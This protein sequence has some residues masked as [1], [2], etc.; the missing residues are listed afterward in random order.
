MQIK[1]VSFSESKL[2]LANVTHEKITA[3]IKEITG[4]EES[5]L[6]CITQK[7]MFAGIKEGIESAEI[8]LVAVDISRFISTKASLFRA[9]GFKCRLNSE[10]VQLIGSDACMATLN[11]NQINAHAAIPVGGEAFVTND[12]LFSGFGIKSGKQK[13]IFVPIDD[14]RI[15]AV[16]ENGMVDFI[17]G[18]VHYKV[19]QEEKTEEV[20]EEEITEEIQK[21]EIV[22]EN[23]EDVVEETPEETPEEEAAETPAVSDIPVEMEGYVQ[24]I[25]NFQ[26]PVAPV[27]EVQEQVSEEETEDETEESD[28]EFEDIASSSYD[29]NNEEEEVS[30][31]S[32]KV[33]V[34]T[35]SPLVSN[36]AIILSRGA[37]IAVARQ[38]ENE[39]YTDVL[40]EIENSAAVEFVDFPL[41]KSIT[42]DIRRKESVASN[43]RKAMKQ[44]NADFAISI[45]E[46]YK[47]EDGAE[48]I[49][50]TL[51][52]E[53]KSSVFKIFSVTGETHRDLYKTGLE[54]IVEKIEEMSREGN[55]QH[56]FDNAQQDSQQSSDKKPMGLATKLII[57]VLAVVA[58]CAL[59]AL[60]IDAVMSNGAAM[61]IATSDIVQK[62]YNLLSR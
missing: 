61:S 56:S 36:L 49:F 53:Q 22:Q 46:V 17:F 55:Y 31:P 7:E 51:A 19:T 59:S 57:W 42:E 39:V 6:Y 41:E 26:P 23:S 44:I 47:A 13:L 29:E 33:P 4:K 48:Y 28:D 45:S 27:S 20:A 24:P 34:A 43:A 18:D 15:D 54:S 21:E 58:L 50:A 5:F 1:L 14:K 11:E 30:E 16:I 8:I 35:E 38:T 12:G 25:E 2:V 9:L 52:D 40:S 60:I 10:I 62:A 3:K 32:F 37:K